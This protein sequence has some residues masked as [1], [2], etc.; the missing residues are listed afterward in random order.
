MANFSVPLLN[1]IVNGT[2][3]KL[4]GTTGTAGTAALNIYTGTMP[5]ST[6]S[7]ATGLLLCTISGIGWGPSTNGTANIAVISGYLGTAVTSGVAGWARIATVTADGTMGIDG[8]C[9]TD[10]EE[11]GID[12]SAIE[13]DVEIKLANYGLLT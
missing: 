1:K 5:G 10:G 8:E 11:I 9:G 12:V 13:T 7:A 2:I 6:G 4:A 3:E